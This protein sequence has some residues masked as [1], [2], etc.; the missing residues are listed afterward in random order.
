MAAYAFT[1]TF[2]NHV[3]IHFLQNLL[4]LMPQEMKDCQ[5]TTLGDTDRRQVVK[6]QVV[7]WMG[8]M[9]RRLLSKLRVDIRSFFSQATGIEMVPVQTNPFSDKVVQRAKKIETA[10]LASA[11]AMW[12]EVTEELLASD[13]LIVVMEKYLSMIRRIYKLG[14]YELSITDVTFIIDTV[15]QLL[16]HR[17]LVAR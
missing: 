3:S 4:T 16:H 10:K 5:L 12:M 6:T 15:Q 7:P 11:K 9:K 13:Q 14:F 1:P 8:E 17:T 2:Q